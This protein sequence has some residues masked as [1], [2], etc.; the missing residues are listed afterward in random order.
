[1]PKRVIAYVALALALVVFLLAA[2][3]HFTMPHYLLMAARV[4]ASEVTPW[5]VALALIAGALALAVLE[6]GVLPRAALAIASA[7]L[8]LAAIPLARLP[9]AI[10]AADRE[11]DGALGAEVTEGRPA[12]SLATTLLGLRAPEVVVARDLEFTV[13]GASL[14]LD[15]YLPPTGGAGRPAIVMVHGGSWRGG[16]KG[17]SLTSTTEWSRTLAAG[18]FVVYDIQ[19]RLAPAVRHPVPFEDVLCAL[20]HVRERSTSDGVDPERVVLLGR[21]AGAHLALLAA[22]RGSEAPCGRPAVVRGVVALYGPT[23]LIAAYADPGDPDL[24]G[25]R[26]IFRDL[27]GGT[28]DEVRERYLDAMPRTWLDGAVPTLLVHGQADQ[29]VSPRHSAEL[30][31]RLREHGVPVAHVVLPWSG[32]SFDAIGAGVGGQLALSAVERFALAVVRAP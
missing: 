1:M 21:S 8:V 19:Y 3:I 25:A 31:A 7:A 26:S 5:L 14:R 32:H 13:V 9:A 20:A 24:I 16:D 18:G 29:I 6:A 23:E 28:P 2:S 17:Q 22:Y 27:L 15:R 4:F 10:A 30:A 12:F 11:L